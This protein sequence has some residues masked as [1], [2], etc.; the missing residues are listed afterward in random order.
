MNTSERIYNEVTDNIIKILESGNIPWKKPWIG[1]NAPSNLVSK[2]AYRGINSIVLGFSPFAKTPYWL[3][4][5]QCKQLGGWVQDLKHPTLIVFYAFRDYEKTD[6]KGVVKTEKVPMLKHYYVYNSSQCT[7]LKLP[8][9]KT[10][11]HA[12]IP[13]A[14]SVVEKYLTKEKI[15]VS[16][17]GRCSY[18][19]SSDS[20][21]MVP[22]TQ[23][24][25]IEE[26]YST[27]FHEMAHSTGHQTRLKR[28]GIIESNGFGSE[29]Y[30]K[31]E[32]VAEMTASFISNAVGF[33][34][35]AIENAA[36][37]IQ[38]WL[39]VLKDDKKM[40]VSAAGAAQKAADYIIDAPKEVVI[41]PTA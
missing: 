8:E 35:V 4:L 40:V 30:S 25:K 23:F 32:L 41:D 33:G 12:P 21:T 6:K 29:L 27:M 9:T 15:Q 3:T 13:A 37:Y 31:E 16:D 5:N 36:A 22:V 34:E 18:S 20:I 7:G 26:F 10:F 28:A 11:E 19:P 2:K 39:K 38:N 14:Y 1:G 17:G 24:P